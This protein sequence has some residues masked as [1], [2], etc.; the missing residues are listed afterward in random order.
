MLRDA[1]LS[2]RLARSST[3]RRLPPGTHLAPFWIVQ[4]APTNVLKH[5]APPEAA[6]CLRCTEAAVDIGVVNHGCAPS[7]EVGGHAL[8]GMRERITLY[9][10]AFAAG[11]REDDEFAVSVHLPVEAP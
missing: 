10:G 1:G 6:T 8:V 3:P 2:V 9:G 7:S 5:A 4:E 11:P